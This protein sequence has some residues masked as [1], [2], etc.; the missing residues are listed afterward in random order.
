[1]KANQLT[2]LVQ[3]NIPPQEQQQQQQQ[4]QHFHRSALLKT[5]LASGSGGSNNVN[6]SNNNNNKNETKFEMDFSH[7]KLGL[8]SASTSSSTAA[9]IFGALNNNNNNNNSQIYINNNNNNSTTINNN[10]SVNSNAPL[11][12]SIDAAIKEV[13]SKD[14]KDIPVMSA[15]PPHAPHHQ[16][17]HP[18][19][20]HQL[21]G[22]G[23]AIRRFSAN[24]SVT[25]LR[26]PSANNNNNNNYNTGGR[27]RSPAEV[28]GKW[29]RFEWRRRC[30]DD[31]QLRPRE[32]GSKHRRRHDQS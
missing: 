29:R 21:V 18:P 12:L 13:V 10:S 16:P 9:G 30:D 32:S 25:P 11:D 4:Q 15:K 7:G 5:I 6:Q 26:F 8:A 20:H 3:R 31:A 23:E 2:S 28:G 14:D 19:H 22:G 17:P 24:Q 27:R 1:M